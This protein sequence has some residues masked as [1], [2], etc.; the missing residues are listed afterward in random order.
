MAA[1]I[2]ILISATI[3]GLLGTAHLILTYRGPKLLPREPSVKESMERVHPRIT[4]QTTMWRAWLGFN[5]SHSLGAMLFG[6]VYGYLALQ[7][8]ALLFGSTFLQVLGLLVLVAY[9][10][11]ARAYWF[12]TPLAGTSL[13]LACYVV[14]LALS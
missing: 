5:A 4:S 1:S 9:V 10:L 12:R 6:A 8:P 14:A 2:L 3:I 13:A 7:Q 11:M